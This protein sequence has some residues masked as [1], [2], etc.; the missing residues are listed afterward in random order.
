MDEYKKITLSDHLFAKNGGVIF[1][2]G[3]K[4]YSDSH[5][6]ELYRYYEAF[7][8][9]EL[10]KEIK[11]IGFFAF[12]YSETRNCDGERVYCL[13][14]SQTPSLDIFLRRKQENE[15]VIPS[16]RHV[17]PLPHN[18]ER[19]ASVF[20]FRDH[21]IVSDINR[22]EIS[23]GKDSEFACRFIDFGKQNVYFSDT[24]GIDALVSHLHRFTDAKH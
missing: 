12:A 1:F 15:V 13:V 9:P 7:T 19:Y 14:I 6:V 21:Y 20:F 11:R 3:S 24:R 10:L 22:N 8:T 5:D 2:P 17:S 16:T 18:N 23:V 4:H